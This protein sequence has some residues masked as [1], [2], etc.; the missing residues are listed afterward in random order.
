MN[1]LLIKAAQKSVSLIA[2]FALVLGR[3]GI[4]GL[5]HAASPSTVKVTIDKFI[6]G[7][8]ATSASAGGLPFQMTATWNATSTGAG[9]GG[10]SLS[11]TGFNSPNSYEAVTAD[12]TTGA[13]YS[14]SEDT[15][16]GTPF[17][18]SGYTT[19]TTLEMAQT[20]TPVMTMPSF[21]G[22]TS[23]EYVIVW[24]TTTPSTTVSLSAPTPTSPA[25]STTTT[26]ANLT[27]INWTPVTDTVGGVSYVFQSSNSSA[28][29]TDGSF[30]RPVY[31]SAM[32]STNSVPTSGTPEGTYYWHVQATD[33]NGNMSPWSTTWSFIV[34]NSDTTTTPPG[35]TTGGLGG[36]VTGGTSSHG[37]LAVTS[38]ST[39]AI[40][41]GTFTHGWKYVFNITIPDNE[42]NLS[43]KFANW[44]NTNSSSTMPVAGNMRISSPQ[45][46]NANATIVLSAANVFST[47]ALHMT[48]DLDSSMMGKQVQ[49]TVETAVPL[50]TVNGSYTT[51]YA[52]QTLP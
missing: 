46:D 40:A 6:D 23:D 34:N 30:T 37:T 19:G 7:K 10:F 5:A 13:D 18:L 33:A 45:A 2:M 42:K 35:G 41:D 28:T 4:S 32:L 27:S 15:T 21:T 25:N 14:V 17:T 11:P 50:N 16:S 31:T 39:T 43:M 51:T 47:P 29:N 3:F 26:S 38:V 22:M 44:L 1:R 9:S 12:M 8:M 24:N 48:D 36:D 20:A 49:I 52:V